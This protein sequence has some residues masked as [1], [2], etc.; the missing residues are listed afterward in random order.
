MLGTCAVTELGF[1]RV[2]VQAGI[3]PDVNTA[4]V[5]LRQFRASSPIKAELW[6]D[7][8]GADRWPKQVKKPSDLTDGHRRE[9]ARANNATFVT[10]DGGVPG[11]MLIP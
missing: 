1:V 11:A 2:C 4:V 5:A 8:L 10:L 6:P 9:L 3:Q 7:D